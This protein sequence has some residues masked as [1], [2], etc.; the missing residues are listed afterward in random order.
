LSNDPADAAR[1]QSKSIIG[2]RLEACPTLSAI[3][4]VLIGDETRAVEAATALRDRGIFVPAI[5]YP[6]VARGKARLR[7]TLTA[8]HTPND[9]SQLVAALESIRNSDKSRAREES[10]CP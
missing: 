5:R 1:L 9:I 2:D 6:T 7:V 4:P 10:Q 8:T 3:I